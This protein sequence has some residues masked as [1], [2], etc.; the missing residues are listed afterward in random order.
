MLLSAAASGRRAAPAPG[1]PQAAGVT[2]SSG[3][4]WFD[5]EADRLR[6][7]AR[8]EQAAERLLTAVSAIRARDGAG[9][10]SAELLDCRPPNDAERVSFD[11]W[12][13]EASTEASKL[14]AR[15]AAFDADRST[16][17][18]IAQF[19]A[20]VATGALATRRQTH[21]PDGAMPGGREAPGGQ[22][23][24]V[25]PSAEEMAGQIA[26][27]LDRVD[28]GATQQ[29]RDE[30]TSLAGEVLSAPSGT[31]QT[32]LTDLR[33]RVQQ[34]DR[35]VAERREYAARAQALLLS[36][37]ELDGPAVADERELLGEVAAGR[38]VLAEADVLRIQRVRE[39]AI[40]ER[41]REFVAERL[42]L[43]LARLGYHLD[44]RFLGE[45]RAGRP[46]FAVLAASEQHA[47]RVEVGDGAFDYRLVRTVEGDD[48]VRDR[49]LEADLCG[50]MGR[51]MADVY[52]E[53]V[54]FRFQ[55]H[56]D[57]GSRP[58]EVSRAAAVVADRRQRGTRSPSRLR[59]RER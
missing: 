2:M 14:E 54:S 20:L 13:L 47:V 11:S 5:Y 1:A 22:N 59:E 7:R 6:A 30:L 10:A 17:G 53:G 48:P 25:G 45:V 15:A 46:G 23:V 52:P 55:E 31:W 29:E 38:G 8:C 4:G 9:S 56:R 35:A 19:R 58:L 21:G 36:L 18:L 43:T 39:A 57:P 32:L 49:A 50:D 34:V 12:W 44:E 42:A 40:A 3:R 37:E 51:F 16:G 24:A 41:E 33:A 27:V 26:G 28:P